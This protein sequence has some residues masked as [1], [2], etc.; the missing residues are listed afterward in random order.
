MIKKLIYASLVGAVVQFV[1]GWVVFGLLLSKFMSSQS[2][3]YD[4]LMKDMSSPAFMILVFISGLV[5]SFFIAF[6]FQR[7]AKFGT[8]LKGLYGG[9]FIGFFIGLAYD[10]SSYAMLNMMSVTGLIVDVICSCILTGILGAVIAW[11]LGF[12]TKVVPAQ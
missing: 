6:I 10:I 8:F 5:M 9:M 2:I 1:L 4:G 3:Q 11:I 12:K 7:W